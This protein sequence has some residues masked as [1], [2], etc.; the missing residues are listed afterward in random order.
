M[1]DHSSRGRAEHVG[2]QTT[3]LLDPITV[4]P[5]GSA[6]DLGCGSGGALG[7]LSELVGP[8]GR[9]VGVDP[10]EVSLGA[11]RALVRERALDNVEIVRADAR[12]TGLSR[13]SFDLVHVRMLLV[14]LPAPEQV[15]DEIARLVKPGGWVAAMEPDHALRVCYPPHHA[16]RRLSELLAMAYR[17]DGADGYVGRRLPHLLATA[18]LANIAVEAHAPVYPPGHPHR[19]LCPDL[20]RE[21]RPRI[22]R[23]GL[24]GERELDRLDH[25][26]RLHLDDPETLSVP[27]TYFAAWARKPAWAA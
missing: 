19:T 25:A 1:N 2:E 16:L 3:A 18:G 20:V 7:L 27:V 15:V 8:D 5:G 21:L 24:I 14:N 22:L 10:D 23:W 11:A 9:V 13:S 26:A 6:L 17:H 4:A 12:E